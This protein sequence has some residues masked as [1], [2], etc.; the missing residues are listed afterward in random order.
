MMTKWL[1]TLDLTSVWQNGDAPE[2]DVHMIG[3]YIAEQLR[4]LYP[5]Y[6]DSDKW[7]FELENLIEDFDNILTLEEYENDTIGFDGFTPYADFNERMRQ[8][9]DF[10]D[11]HKLWVKTFF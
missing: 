2:S 1:K 3:K 11:T 8:L 10:A 6:T 4:L 5:D 9:Y 7:G